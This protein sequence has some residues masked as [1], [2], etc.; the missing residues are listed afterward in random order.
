MT[1][2]GHYGPS[3]TPHFHQVSSTPSLHTP[4]PNSHT[5][6]CLKLSLSPGRVRPGSP[7][8]FAKTLETLQ[9]WEAKKIVKRE[10]LRTEMENAELETATFHPLLAPN[11][12]RIM[13]EQDMRA[14]L[15]SARQ[16]VCLGLKDSV[17]RAVGRLQPGTKTHFDQKA[18]VTVSLPGSRH[19]SPGPQQVAARNDKWLQARNQK[20]QRQKQTLPPGATFSPSVNVPAKSKRREQLQVSYNQSTKAT[21]R[22]ETAE[23][24]AD[25]LRSLSPVAQSISYK[26]GLDLASFMQRARPLVAMK[27]LGLNP[28]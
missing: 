5:L 25:S 17:A 12:L 23:V 13:K 14:A 24:K 1:N 19:G 22:A 21:I 18:F 4:Y 15:S 27:D 2:R 10:H 6:R 9:A 8:Q 11:T 28:A 26:A 3:A 7:A 16:E 20:I